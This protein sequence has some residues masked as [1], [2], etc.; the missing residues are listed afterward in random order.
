MSIDPLELYI[1]DNNLFNITDID[2]EMQL[3]AYQIQFTR[4]ASPCHHSSISFLSPPQISNVPTN[5]S[6]HRQQLIR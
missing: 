6:I 5:T 4:V 2:K 3:F 1:T